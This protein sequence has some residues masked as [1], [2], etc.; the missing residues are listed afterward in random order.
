MLPTES[1]ANET[2]LLR[3][4]FIEITDCVGG[5]EAEAAFSE[6]VQTSCFV[7]VHAVDEDD[8]N[9]KMTFVFDP[10]T[11]RTW[12]RSD[13]VDL[14]ASTLFFE[15]ITLEAVYSEKCKRLRSND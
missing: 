9:T 12:A 10:S 7:F 5:P 3:W 13:H 15:D 1:T 4:G 6:V 11:A 8:G 14:D 2:L